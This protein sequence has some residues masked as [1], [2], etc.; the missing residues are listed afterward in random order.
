MWRKQK[1]LSL[2]IL[3]VT[4]SSL[5]ITILY[6]LLIHQNPP[7]QKYLAYLP[8]SGLSNQRIELANALL[9]AAI[10]KRTLVIPPAFLGTVVGWMPMDQ[11]LEHLTWLTT[12]KDFDKLCPPTLPGQLSTYTHMSKCAE[13]HQFAA[14]PWHQLHDFSSLA[15]HVNIR[16]QDVVSLEKLKIDLNVIDNDTYV[17]LDDHLYDWRLYEDIDAAKDILLNGTNFIDSFTDR[18]FYKIYTLDHWIRRPE[19]LLHLGG[20]FGSTRMNMIKPQ[21]LELQQLIAD[22]LHYR[23]DTPLGETVAGIV[24]HLGGKGS[25]MSLHFRLKDTPFRKYANENLKS[26]ERNMSIATGIPVPP[27][28]PMDEFGIFTSQ[29][30]PPP[31]PKYTVPIDPQ[32]DLND[33]PWT[34]MCENV[35]P[36]LNTSIDH[37]GSRA[38][39]YMAT[40]HRDVRADNSRLLEWFDYFPCTLTLSDM[41]DHLFAPLDRMHCMFSTEKPLKSFLIPLVDAMVAAHARRI[42]TTPRSTFSKYIGELNEAW[43]LKEQGYTLASFW[44]YGNQSVIPK[45]DSD[46]QAGQ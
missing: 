29:P 8:H 45:L 19:K 13:Y 31:V 27:L 1:K 28:P 25:F 34:N 35:S 18:K 38:V 46:I 7:E 10:L 23:L 12:P 17:H 39:V 2:S 22:T 16:F 5:I 42:F 36:L 26:F 14:I 9:L 6:L 30:Q 33:V 20:I 21:H 24:D 41:P 37:I 3:S 43:I 44:E 32:M 40:D 4:I 15:P 11:L